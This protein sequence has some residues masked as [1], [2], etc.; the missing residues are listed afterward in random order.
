MVLPSSSVSFHSS[1]MVTREGGTQSTEPRLTTSS[2]EQD[3]ALL[4][5]LKDHK[6]LSIRAA[7]MGDLASTVE[8]IREGFSDDPEFDYRF[9][10]RHQHPEH[11]RK[12]KVLR[13]NTED[14]WK[15]H[16]SSLSTLLNAKAVWLPSHSMASR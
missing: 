3:K 11:Y 1:R 8:F 4:H 5:A 16:P 2:S 12:G 13:L 15:I 9:P 6:K 10:K 14:I 7:E